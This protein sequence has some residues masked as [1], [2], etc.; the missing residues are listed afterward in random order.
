MCQ[1]ERV[2]RQC[3]K[4]R[5]GEIKRLFGNEVKIFYLQYAIDKQLN[6]V[7]LVSNSF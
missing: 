7:H 4:S 5:L 3:Q 1:R 2:F 6:I